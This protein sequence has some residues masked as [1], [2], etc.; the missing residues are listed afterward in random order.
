VRIPYTGRIELGG[1][2]QPIIEAGGMEKSISA[3]TYNATIDTPTNGPDMSS[4]GAGIPT[5]SPKSKPMIGTR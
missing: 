2:N 5:R 3:W 1:R 4:D